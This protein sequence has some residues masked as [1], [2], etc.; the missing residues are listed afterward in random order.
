VHDKV[1]ERITSRPGRSVKVY[2]TYRTDIPVQRPFDTIGRVSAKQKH[3]PSERNLRRYHGKAQTIYAEY[4]ICLP[5]SDQLRYVS[6]SASFLIGAVSPPY[7]W[8]S[9]LVASL[10]RNRTKQD[11]WISGSGVRISG[12]S[13]TCLFLDE[14][15]RRKHGIGSTSD[16]SSSAN[17]YTSSLSSAE[18]ATRCMPPLSSPSA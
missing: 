2:G 4:L 16:V 11:P 6:I 10:L 17:F 14:E 5:W 1:R 8:N 9:F 12:L 13:P 18:V 3:R 7:S 15:Y